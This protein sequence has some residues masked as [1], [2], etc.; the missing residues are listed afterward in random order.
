MLGVA[1]KE[2][3]SVP[4]GYETKLEMKS[5]DF[6]E[7][8]WALGYGEDAI[9]YLREYYTKEERVPN[10]TNEKYL[11][12]IK[13][14]IVIGGM[15]DVV[16]KY[17]ETKNF[18][19]VYNEQTKLINSYYDDIAKYAPTTEKIKAKACYRSVNTQL[20][21]E[22][23]KFKYSSV[24]KN[25]NA[26]KYENSLDWL[27]DAGLIKFCY[28]VTTP[29]Y[30]LPHYNST[31]VFKVYPTDIGLLTAMYGFDIKSAIINDTITGEAKGGIYESLMADMLFKKGIP[32][33]YYR[34]NDNMEIEFLI[35]KDCKIIPLEVKSGNSATPSLNEYIKQFK[36]HLTLKFGSCNVGRAD[37]KLTLPLY[38]AMFI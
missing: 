20:S 26:R 36:P 14:Y 28:N 17:V 5:M 6:E 23:K 18:G 24:E 30:P 1:Y 38:M 16:K 4:V 35:A 2:T 32:L 3:D 21:R 25:G 12:L 11:G 29:T 34:P 9:K 22:N 8:L 7:F 10:T 27:H 37:T 19:E 13:E 31:G 33:N 15:P